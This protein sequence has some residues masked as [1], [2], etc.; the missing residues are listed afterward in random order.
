MKRWTL[1]VLTLL[2]CAACA[3]PR[4]QMPQTAA[5]LEGTVSRAEQAYTKLYQEYRAGRLSKDAL[6]QGDALYEAW[7]TTQDL[8]MDAVKAGAI[9]LKKDGP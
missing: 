5:D 2:L 4:Y 1:L 9:R 3:A 7:R 8:L 6:T